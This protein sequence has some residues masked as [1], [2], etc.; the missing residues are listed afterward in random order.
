MMYILCIFISFHSNNAGIGHRPGIMGI[1]FGKEAGK[2]PVECTIR[3][4]NQISNQA[5]GCKERRRNTG[6][7][8]THV[9]MI[10][11][12]HLVDYT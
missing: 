11:T 9:P 6:G 3:F 7:I 12:Y 10:I 2:I 8:M 1:I 4:S 5:L